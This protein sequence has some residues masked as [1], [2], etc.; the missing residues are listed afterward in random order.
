MFF[1]RPPG[2]LQGLLAGGALG[3]QAIAVAE[4]RLADGV[5]LGGCRFGRL[6]APFRRLP[7][8]QALP[9]CRGLV[10]GGLTIALGTLVLLAAFVAPLL[11]LLQS[12][13]L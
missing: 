10:L 6:P 12:G 2:R 13:Q 4:R 5:G 3:R 7:V 1:L 8:V 11:F 9:G